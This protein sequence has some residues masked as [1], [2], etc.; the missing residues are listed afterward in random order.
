MKR[1]VI[2]LTLFLLAGISVFAQVSIND[3]NTPPDNSAMLDVKSIS[4]GFLPP[5]MTT[6]E[7]NSIIAPSQG[8]LVYNITVNSLFWFNGSTWKQFNEPYMETDPVFTA[9]PA[10]GITVGNIGNWNAA[11][12]WGN[13]A[14]AGYLTSYTETDPIFGAHPASGITVVSIGNWN[15]AYGWGNHATAGY[16]TS[17]TE[18]DPIF[19][20]HPASGITAGN[21]TNWNSAYTNRIVSAAGTAPLT[22]SIS[23]NQLSGSIT[24]AN[25]T[26]N[27]FLTSAN[28]NTFN[29]KQNAL[30]FGN[31][32]SGDLTIT[33]GNGAI[34]GGG[35]TLS[36]NK[37]SL[38]S[39]DMAITGG[40]GSVLGSGTSMTINKGNLTEATSAVL[41]ISGGTGSVLGSGVSL[42]VKQS[43]TSQS[44]YL[45]NTDWNT[46]NNKQSTLTFGNLTSSD[47][48]VS[49]GTGAVKGAGAGMTIN[50]GN[51][52]STDITV[53]GGSGSVL[54][55]GTALTINKG[56]ITSPDMTIIGGSS[57]VLGTGTSLTLN[58]GNLTESGSSVLT[59]TGGGNS[60]VGT[61]T[62][63]QVKQA[64]TTQSGYLS[65]TDW[66][67][68][69]NKVSSQ[70]TANGLKL[71]YNTGNVG[72][73]TTNPQSKIDIAGNAVIGSTY[74]G[75]NAAPA[76]G[77]LV[78]G[79]VGVGTN[80]PA[81][82]ALMELSSTTNGVLLPR[83]TYDQRNVIVNPAEG[84]MV[85]CTNCGSNGALSIY[86]N[87][88]WR[89]FIP[90]SS[91]PPTPGTH[92][93]S[94]GQIIWNWNP[95]AGAVGYKWNT[96][97]NYG[98][99]TEMNTATSKAETGI[100]CGTTYTRYVWAYNECE[101]SVPVTLTQTVSAIVPASPSPGTHT[102]TQIAI[103]WNWNT[104]SDAIGYKWNTT[105]N[106]GTAT[107]MGTATAK[108]ETGLTCGT[109]YTRYVWAYNGCGYS[110]VTSVNQSTGPCVVLPTVTTIA[111]TS[112]AQTTATSGGNVTWDGGGT[113]TARGVCWSLLPNPTTSNFK[114]V[115]G[116]GTGIFTS[117]MT[118]LALNTLYYVKAYAT[119]SVGTTYGDQVSFTT[120]SFAIGQ[121]YGG[122]IIFYLDGTGQHGL[123]S[124]TSDQS[125]GAQWGCYGTSIP[126][127]STALGTGQA[128]TTLI[129]NGCSEAD[130]AARICNDL[131]L[132][133]YDDWFLPSKD[134]LSLMYAQKTA[135]GGFNNAN[136]N[137]YW[138]SSG[139]GDYGAWYID[140]SYYGSA[141][142]YGKNNSSNVRAV[143]AF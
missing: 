27:G 17:Y 40:S 91:M 29:N 46:F 5:R 135:I 70:W 51:L 105:D 15:T 71:F 115:D 62:D 136:N 67:S 88:A 133:S 80:A 42:Q 39:S 75:T 7:M 137:P 30:T 56:N 89:T 35:M 28:W 83:M 110:L 69:N 37:G 90:C 54:G 12:G 8:L 4:R 141:G 74:S 98:S 81:P 94:P 142:I 25:S 43:G 130:R 18:T 95:V 93:L 16:L 116:S 129:V 140:F 24:A 2:I 55:T 10:S 23:S 76:N 31:A 82:S 108:T 112:I 87:S 33:G 102:A 34:I 121:S 96:T 14:T 111:A 22:L 59:I 52:T 106:F 97:T 19:G 41:T 72:L 78:E 79:K 99:A 120:I 134:E 61:G 48:S 122:G 45:S 109:A 32:T 107:E 126:G 118:G 65:N 53:T 26:T 9:H 101:I 103:V 132:N 49:G 64:N 44:G 77:L 1:I 138:S 47:I 84:L 86:S 13:H 68:F 11:Y 139:D 38:T 114:T 100:S 21:I 127:T 50:K 58:K 60:V 119:N 73:G 57:S 123:I 143:R 66:N 131:V 63:I 104:V 6:I 113:I 128:N 125:T 92:A 117:S 124:A 85:F 20:A 3:D 36:V